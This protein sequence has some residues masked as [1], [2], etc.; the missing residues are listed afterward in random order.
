MSAVALFSRR[1]LTKGN[2]IT[3]CRFSWE[4][5]ALEGLAVPTQALALREPR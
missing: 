2:A 5:D 4:L 1:S 3:P